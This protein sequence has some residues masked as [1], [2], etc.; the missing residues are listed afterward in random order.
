M[1][2]VVIDEDRRFARLLDAAHEIERLLGFAQREP[3]RRLVED[4]KFRVEIERPGDRHALLLA[5]RHG[6]DDVVRMHGSRGESH[7]LA[8]QP[9]RLRAHPLDV[10]ETEARARLAPHEH[11]APD[12]LLLA[13]RPLLIDGLDAETARPRNRPIVDLP[14]LEI[15]LSPGIRPIKS[16]HDLHQRRLA[17]AI[18][19][20]QADDL[21]VIDGKIHP[22]KRPHFAERL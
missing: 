21:A 1:K 11:V 2:N 14:S 6:G 22:R 5:A 17:G 18:V 12:R 3:H 7:M 8:H 16:H 20:E 15:D 10:E 19:A 9:G 13:Q 4:D